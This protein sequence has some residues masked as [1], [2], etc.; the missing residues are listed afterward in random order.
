MYDSSFK[1]IITLCKC[2][3]Q[4]KMEWKSF[5]FVIDLQ[6]H[7]TGTKVLEMTR[8]FS[9]SFLKIIRKSAV[10]NTPVNVQLKVVLTHQ[11]NLRLRSYTFNSVL[12]RHKMLLR[13]LSQSHNIILYLDMVGILIFQYMNV[14]SHFLIFIFKHKC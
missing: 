3:T 5:K 10:P 4:V 6:R 8:L 7:K 2:I 13:H 14:N 9:C 1:H 12:F 11:L